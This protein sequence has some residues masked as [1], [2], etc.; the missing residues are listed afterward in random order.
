MKKTLS[1]IK[2]HRTAFIIVLFFLFT[3]WMQ[4]CQSF[5]YASH[6]LHAAVFVSC[7]LIYFTVCYFC[8]RKK[9]FQTEDKIFLITLGGILLRSFYI[10]FTGLYDRQHDGGT[11][12]SLSDDLINIGHLGYVEFLCKFGHIPE[13]SPYEIFSYYHPPVH[14]ILASLFIE[15]QLLL[16]VTEKLAFENIQALTGLYSALCLPLMYA[17]LKKLNLKDSNIC[18]AFALLTF[19]PGM[20]YMSASINNDML[21]T[22]MTLLCFYF[23]LCW[24][25]EKTFGNLMKIALSLGIG[26]ITKLNCSVMAFPLAAIFLMDFIETLKKKKEDSTVRIWPMIRNYLI[27]G[28]VTASI[29]LSWVMRNLIKF[30]DQPGVP[31]ATEESVQ[32]TGNF[33]LWQLFGIPS[34]LRMD[35]PFH[36]TYARDFCNSWLILFR[37]SIFAETNPVDLPD[38]MFALCQFALLL[39]MILGCSLF[40][41]TILMEIREIKKGDRELG[42]YL[43]T[44]YIF[45]IITF[46][47]FIIKYPFTCSAD[48]RYVVIGLVMNAVAYLQ[49]SDKTRISSRA[50]AVTLKI[51]NYLLLLF[52]CLI[53]SIFVLWNQW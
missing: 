33:S 10:L 5:F 6:K 4:G 9:Q 41:I 35:L 40:V 26:M 48:F 44:G 49:F 19:H 24:M 23:G 18:I 27:F 20:I 29:G 22:L 2:R 28:I 51:L 37:T 36:T 34:S 12:S 43:L 14:H 42:I 17:I 52:L 53:T 31:V 11:F 38:V 1:Y 45:V 50:H 21:C 25:K 30:G 39:A 7:I 32:Y 16:G 8:S 15:L 46:I 3:T 47:A 13:F